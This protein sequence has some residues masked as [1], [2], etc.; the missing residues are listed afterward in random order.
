MS[1]VLRRLAPTLRVT[2]QISI[3]FDEKSRPR[4]F[5]IGQIEDPPALEQVRNPASVASLASESPDLSSKSSD[6]SD[7]A[8]DA[9]VGTSVGPETLELSSNGDESRACDATDAADAKLRTCSK[10]GGLPENG[11]A[12]ISEPAKPGRNRTKVGRNSSKTAFRVEM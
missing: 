11:P 12:E 6:A 5:T 3:V 10:D 9:S 7:V 1:S 4:K 2:D 8:N